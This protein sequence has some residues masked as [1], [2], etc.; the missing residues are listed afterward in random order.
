MLGSRL[1]VCLLFLAAAT[2]FKSSGHEDLLHCKRAGKGRE[3]EV[4]VYDR[5]GQL[6][7]FMMGDACAQS[8]LV[9]AI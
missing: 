5:A 1:F 7:M 9:V 6:E 2:R 8:R 4:S 3:H